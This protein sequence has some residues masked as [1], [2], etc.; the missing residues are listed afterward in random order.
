MMHASSK[1]S[2]PALATERVISGQIDDCV[3]ADERADDQRRQQFPEMVNVP[4]G[5]AEE[6]VI[7]RKVTITDRIAGDDQISNVAMPDRQDPS[8]DQEAKG[9]KTRLG[10]NGREGQ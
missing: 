8:G 5:V 1:D 9:L 7:V 2:Q 3:L 6:S 10:E 4:N